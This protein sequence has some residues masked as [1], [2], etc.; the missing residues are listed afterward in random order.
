MNHSQ[1]RSQHTRQQH[2]RHR[3][4]NTVITLSGTAADLN[5]AYGSSDVSGLGNE[6]VFVDSGSATTAEANTLAASTTGVVTATISDGDISTLSGLNETSNAY[7][8][9]ITDSSIDASALNTLDSTTSVSVNGSNITSLSGSAEDLNT[10]YDSDGISNLGDED[11]T[12]LMHHSQQTQ[13]QHARQQ[14]HRHRQRRHRQHSLWCRGESQHTYD[15]DGISNLGDEE[16]T[17]TD[18]SL[19]ANTL[20]TLDSNTG[21]TVNADT[22][23]TRALVPQQIS[24]PPTTPTASQPR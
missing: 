7:T 6:D 18:A 19:A 9:T 4:R 2:H 1:R 21:G 16:I 20:N 23:N 13:A 3:Q 8:I 22:V 11:I 17:L 24:T 15:S 12:L 14:H 5:T 10:A